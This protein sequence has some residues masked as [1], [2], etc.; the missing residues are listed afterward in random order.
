MAITVSTKCRTFSK[1]LELFERAVELDPR[2]PQRWNNLINLLIVMQRFDDAQ[3][4]LE[5]F[6][7]AE[8]HGSNARDYRILQEDINRVRQ[9]YLSQARLDA[10]GNN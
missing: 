9:Q 10:T 8:T 7:A 1:G 4:K 3:H 5:Q 6:K 2:E